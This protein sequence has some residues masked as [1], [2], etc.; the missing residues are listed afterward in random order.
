MYSTKTNEKC[1]MILNKNIISNYY[2]FNKKKTL[3]IVIIYD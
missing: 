3:E 2:K 1:K